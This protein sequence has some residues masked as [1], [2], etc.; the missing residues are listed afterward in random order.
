MGELLFRV[1]YRYS[2]L[3]LGFY[4]VVLMDGRCLILIMAWYG[5]RGGL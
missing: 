3:F 1:F 5:R 2:C 4:E